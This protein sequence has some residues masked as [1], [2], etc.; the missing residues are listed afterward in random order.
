MQVV[1]FTEARNN[2]KAICD[3]VYAD[4]EEVII[5]RKNG[6]NVVLISLDEYNALKETAYLLSSPK[7]RER[8]L[9]SLSKAR[10]GRVFSKKLVE[11]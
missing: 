3:K 10:E 2:L 7:N 6:E 1:N 4:S 8:L 9:H 11:S 5:N